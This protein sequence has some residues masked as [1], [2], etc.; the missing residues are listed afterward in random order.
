MS[1]IELKDV[2]PIQH[3]EFDLPEGGGGV[4]LFKGTSG[5]GKTTAIRSLSGLLGDKDSL[6]SLTP[7]DGTEKGEIKGLGRSVSVGK[8]VTSKGAA[9]VPHLVGRANVETLVEPRVVDP[10]ARMKTRI[11]YLLSIG[12]RKLTPKDLLGDNYEEFAPE[13]DIDELLREDDSVVMADKLK[14][15][16]DALALMREREADR[17]TGMATAKIQEAG[18]LDELESSLSY[19]EALEASR[20][21]SGALQQARIHAERYASIVE[22]NARVE[23]QIQEIRDSGVTA[24]DD[25]SQKI[26]DQEMVVEGLSKRLDSAKRTLDALREEQGNAQKRANMLAKLESQLL[27]AGEEPSEEGIAKL[28]QAEAK[29]MEAMNNSASVT[30]RMDAFADGQKLRDEAVEISEGAKR[31]RLVAQTVMEEAKKALPPGPIQMDE[32]VL[33]VKHAGRKKSVPFEELSTGEK[34]RVAMKYAVAS[35]GRSGVIPMS[36]EAWQSLGPELREE[37]ANL[38]RDEQVYIISASVEEGGEL[39]VEDFSTEE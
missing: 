11:R 12:G 32:G 9:T 3:I 21:A 35:V 36:Q 2:G 26:K 18:D 38:A 19:E 20:K 4:K 22:T 33:V 24:A 1:T 30:R 13:L 5:A 16:L 34:W 39:R 29:A 14:R 28:E 37:I 25:L 15:G 23:A 6:S 7:H 27:D 17:M 31:I 10:A 8:K